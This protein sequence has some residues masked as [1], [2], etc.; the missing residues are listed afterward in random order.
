MSL[1]IKNAFNT[2]S[3]VKMAES[4]FRTP[5][6]HPIWNLFHWAYCDPSH[7]NLYHQ[8]GE[9]KGTILSQEGLR[10]GDIL[11]SFISLSMQPASEKIDDILTGSHFGPTKNLDTPSNSHPATIAQPRP[12]GYRRTPN[13]HNSTNTKAPPMP[14]LRLYRRHELQYYRGQHHRLLSTHRSNP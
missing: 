10:Q 1:D 5:R 9:Y 12:L 3:R 14:L 4:L 6:T 8:N 7:L 2:R 13:K 11:A